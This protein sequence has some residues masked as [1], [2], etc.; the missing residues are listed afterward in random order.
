[1]KTRQGFT[2]VPSSENTQGSSRGRAAGPSH[3]AA[4]RRFGLARSF[5]EDFD[6]SRHGVRWKELESEAHATPRPPSPALGPFPYVG[7]CHGRCREKSQQSGAPPP[8]TPCSPTPLLL[9]Q[10]PLPT[11]TGEAA[12]GHPPHLAVRVTPDMAGRK[13]VGRTAAGGLVHEALAVDSAV[14]F[15]FLAEARDCFGISRTT[16]TGCQN[17]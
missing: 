7:G 4:P 17:S 13:A 9:G 3:V 12:S 1:M 14:S 15:P 10:A 5:F 2:A 16:Q 8:A 11:P 6:T